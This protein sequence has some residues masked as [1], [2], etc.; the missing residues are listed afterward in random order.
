V[1]AA[2]DFEGAAAAVR[3]E[4]ADALLIGATAVN[5]ALRPRWLGFAAEQRLPMMAPARQFGAM[6]SYGPEQP[7]IFRRAA[8]FVAKIL[9]GERP[10]ELP[11]EQPTRFEFTVNLKMAKVLGL[12]IPYTVMLRA[13]EVIE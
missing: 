2:A 8:E 1:N 13:T 11:M 7:A 5:V 9:G 10:G 3:R 4:R 12:T 6:L